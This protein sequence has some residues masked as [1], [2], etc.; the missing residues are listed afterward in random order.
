MSRKQ[1]KNHDVMSGKVLEHLWWADD[2][3][4]LNFKKYIKSLDRK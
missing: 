1:I 4:G 2:Q 3:S